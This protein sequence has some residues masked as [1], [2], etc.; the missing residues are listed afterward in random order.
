MPYSGFISDLFSSFLVL[1]LF[2]HTKNPITAA[3]IKKT[4]TPAM[5]PMMG[6]VWGE[7]LPEAS[8][9][10]RTRSSFDFHRNFKVKV[11]NKL[12]ISEMILNETEG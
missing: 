4:R 2:L 7:L 10:L 8:S 1:Q 11:G 6:P 9:E 5:D 3:I 12:T